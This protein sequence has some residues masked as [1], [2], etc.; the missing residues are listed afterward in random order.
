M[1]NKTIEI[2]ETL[3]E[4]I[5]Y[6]ILS[7]S[8]KK[9]ERKMERLQN[10]YNYLLVWKENHDCNNID[11]N[12]LKTD[13]NIMLKDT[14]N[15]LKL[16]KEKEILQLNYNNI[17]KKDNSLIFNNINDKVKHKQKTNINEEIPFSKCPIIKINKDEDL[18]NIDWKIHV[19]TE[20]YNIIKNN[21]NLYKKIYKDKNVNQKTLKE[22]II[23]IINKR[24]M[25]NT[26]Q[27]RYIIRNT[28]LRSFY[29]YDTYKD[30]LKYISFS[31]GKMT[32][33]SNKNWNIF[34][35]YLN[36]KLNNIE[37]VKKNGIIINNVKIV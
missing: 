19:S 34:L 20:I 35:E 14:P 28:L 7:E 17:P 1:N 18:H 22:A 12:L 16:K 2:D 31:F 11:V 6:N 3:I 25:E 13:E 24:D 15:Y 32:R 21:Y 4:K 9:L 27:N 30:D 10:K 29:L 8:Y 23:Y 33:I 37:N 26:K 36:N 5:K